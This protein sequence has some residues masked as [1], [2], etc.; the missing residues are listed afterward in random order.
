MRHYSQLKT[1]CERILEVVMATFGQVGS[2][3]FYTPRA[4]RATREAVEREIV[5]S[6]L[7]RAAALGI[8]PTPL[9]LR[10]L[11]KGL[12]GMMY[13]SNVYRVSWSKD[14]AI[15]IPGLLSFTV[16]IPRSG[17]FEK[18]NA[19]KVLLSVEAEALRQPLSTLWE[20]EETAV[21]AEEVDPILAV[22]VAGHWF[23]VYRWLKRPYPL[24]DEEAEHMAR[25]WR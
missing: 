6:F 23:E 13:A 25:L 19:N 12:F 14:V 17:T 5:E 10:P 2:G 7:N 9:S 3:A 4:T 22:K 8:H 18:F 20:I 24:S 15:S 11:K 1:K 21:L 16:G